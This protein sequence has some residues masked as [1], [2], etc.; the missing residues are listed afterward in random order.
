MERLKAKLQKENPD[1]KFVKKALEST[2]PQR[3]NWIEDCPRE[4][5]ILKKY[6]VFKKSRYV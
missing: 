4:E 3:R 6:P 5:E 2:F 1:K